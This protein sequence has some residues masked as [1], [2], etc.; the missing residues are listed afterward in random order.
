MLR[1]LLLVARRDYIAYVGRRRFWLSLLLTPILLLA[2]VFVPGVL[3]NLQSARTYTVIDHSG[4]A[5][6]A[7]ARRIAAGDYTQL[8]NLAAAAAR[9]GTSAGLPQPLA[10]L[11][12]A[13][14]KLTAP[15]RRA[16]ATVLAAG[17]PAPTTAGPAADLWSERPAFIAWY[18]ALTPKVARALDR[19]LAIARF[20]HLLI[21]GKTQAVLNKAVRADKLFAYFVIGAKPL[22]GDTGFVYGSRN[23]TDTAL[24][25]WF[26]G[27]VNA[28]VR[29]RKVRKTGLPKARARW[30]QTPVIFH[31]RLITKAGAKRVSAAERAAQWL[32]V[33][34][35]YLLFISIFSISQ[36]LM[37]STMEEKSSRIAEV[38][39]GAITPGELM[40]GKVLGSLLVGLTMLCFWVVVIFL[41]LGYFGPSLGAAGTFAKGLLGA[42]SP[43][44]LGWFFAYF[45]LGYLFYGALLGAIGAAVSTIQEAQPYMTPVT[46]LLM[47]PLILMIP[48]VKNP[49]AEYARVLSYIP[50]LTP[51][52]MMNRINAPPPLVDYILTTLLL[53]ASVLVL[54]YFA[55]R[56]FR[57]G[58]LNSG[59]PPKLRQLLAWLRTPT[60]PRTDDAG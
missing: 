45:I 53:V 32:P 3:A 1:N 44:D 46:L 55:G 47:V 42:I 34:Y 31:N 51:F 35:V 36:I 22:A 18:R 28:V 29:A 57:I 59:A 7:V 58:L 16:F 56:I 25:N 9:T 10:K 26:S 24:R 39:L 11:A 21:P 33:G 6:P 50:P 43:T 20:R 30:L 14:E 38:L 4:W 27:E 19:G 13:A 49:T 37:M 15:E 23:L 41:A 5:W 48:I 54:L 17:G 60:P 40:S 52:V 8:L 2:F 12:P